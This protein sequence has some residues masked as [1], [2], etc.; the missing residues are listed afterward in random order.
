[1]STD[2]L[3]IVPQATSSFDVLLLQVWACC[4]LMDDKSNVKNEVHGSLAS[5][6]RK[7]GVHF[8]SSIGLFRFYGYHI[9]FLH[10]KGGLKFAPKKPPNKPTKV[11]PKMYVIWCIFFS[12][13]H[14][15]LL[16]VQGLLDKAW[17]HGVE[18]TV[19]AIL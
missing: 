13:M 6:P 12:I 15:Y 4:H 3:M 9:C 8:C 10:L 16:S 14:G 5:R 1:M 19:S 11:T 2:D 7:V 17:C 18:L